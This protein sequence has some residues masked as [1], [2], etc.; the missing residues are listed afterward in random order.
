VNS[1]AQGWLSQSVSVH[2][3]AGKAASRNV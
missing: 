3:V 2:I 1:A